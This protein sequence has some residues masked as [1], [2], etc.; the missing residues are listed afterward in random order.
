MHFENLTQDLFPGGNLREVIA[1]AIVEYTKEDRIAIFRINRPKALGALNVEG[2]TQL[3]NSLLDFRD[4]DDLWVGIITGTGDKV[5]SAGV[6]IK[7]YLPM[8]KRT[9]GKK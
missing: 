9:T 3:H 1:M 6:D 2:M 8:V 5:F 7:D 4:N